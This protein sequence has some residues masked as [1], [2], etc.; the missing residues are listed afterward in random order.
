MLSAIMDFVSTGVLFGILW[1]I[2]TAAY[3]TMFYI[4]C[5]ILDLGDSSTRRVCV[6]GGLLS[7][8]TLVSMI[9]SGNLSI[10]PYRG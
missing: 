4:L 8:L 7:L 5:I 10:G 9:H 3:T 1:I 2:G 6:I